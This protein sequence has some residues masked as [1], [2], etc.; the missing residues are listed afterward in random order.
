MAN[1]KIVLCFE[2]DEIQAKVKNELASQKRKNVEIEKCTSKAAVYD[3]LKK[4][5]VVGALMTLSC[6]VETWS[7]E[8]IVKIKDSSAKNIVLILQENMYTSDNL[9]Y[10]YENHIFSCVKAGN[11]GVNIREIVKLLYS[12]RTPKEAREEYGLST[13]QDAENSTNMQKRYEEKAVALQDP[14]YGGANTSLG[15]KFFLVAQDM[16]S[17]QVQEFLSLLTPELLEQLKMEEEYYQVLTLLKIPHKRPKNLEEYRKKTQEKEQE[18]EHLAEQKKLEEK[19]L[20]EK[21]QQEELL[22]AQED[23]EGINLL[24]VSELELD[25]A[26]SQSLDNVYPEET[27]EEDDEEDDEEKADCHSALAKVICIVS[28]CAII[29]LITFVAITIK[30]HNQPTNEGV[31][32]IYD[33]TGSDVSMDETKNEYDAPGLVSKESD[34][35]VSEDSME[36]IELSIE[37][38]TKEEVEESPDN[39]DVQAD[40]IPQ[41]MTTYETRKDAEDTATQDQRQEEEKKE[42][43]NTSVTSAVSNV[44]DSIENKVTSVAESRKEASK[45][46]TGT[47]ETAAEAQTS[48][49]PSYDYTPKNLDSS[50]KEKTYKDGEEI[51]GLDV[52]NVI[53]AN[54]SKN[55]YRVINADGSDLTFKKDT[56]TLSDLNVNGKY[57]VST[58]DNITTFTEK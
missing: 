38:K 51:N 19:Q 17:E 45:S 9:K 1:Q 18:K 42:I 44:K 27:D 41:N 58:V 56:A 31:K 50:Y 2:H 28:I 4:S 5:D 29:L 52:L 7:L 34:V 32:T 16:T 35:G 8:E 37:D 25:D 47:S 39:N 13:L 11:Y 30:R 46:T 3:A 40:E 54:L 57:I 22:R 21:K 36:E 10:L 12:E 14:N 15:H 55:T 48:N 49:L 24:G 53:N 6:G 23:D 26:V 43:K 20:E 33:V